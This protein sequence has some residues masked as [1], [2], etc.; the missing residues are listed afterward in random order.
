[1]RF[2]YST[3]SSGSVPHSAAALGRVYDSSASAPDRQAPPAASSKYLHEDAH[4]WALQFQCIG[5]FRSF[6][7]PAAQHLQRQ[8]K[9]SPRQVH[10]ASNVCE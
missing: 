2:A 7:A 4:F 1:M 9:L 10:E 3:K 8:Q 6:P 5:Q